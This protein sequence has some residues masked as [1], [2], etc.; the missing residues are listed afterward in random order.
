M[1]THI[2]PQHDKEYGDD[3]HWGDHKACKSQ[4]DSP[5]S[6]ITVRSSL[7]E[8]NARKQDLKRKVLVNF[9]KNVQP[10]SFR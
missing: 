5:G 9:L 10:V 1:A 6:F 2:G 7:N 4:K 8:T 3:S